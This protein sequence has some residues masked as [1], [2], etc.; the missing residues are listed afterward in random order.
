M[1]NE[2]IFKLLINNKNYDWQQATITGAAIRQLGGIPEET[3]LFL[4]VNGQG[5]DELISQDA[6]VDL[7]RPGIEHFYSVAKAIVL[8]VN[9]RE[10]QWAQNTISFEQ[11]VILAFG[12]ITNNPNTVFTVTYSKGPEDNKAGTMVQGDTVMVKNKMVFNVTATD[13]S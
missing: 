9:G 13:K 11:L 5:D 1:A 7:S 10:K 3:Y 8:I 2:K 4:K 6:I 12:S